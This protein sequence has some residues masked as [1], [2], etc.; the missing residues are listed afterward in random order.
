MIMWVSGF[1]RV[2]R[3][4]SSKYSIILIT[5]VWTPAIT[6][7]ND[8]SAS[9]MMNPPS[10]CSAGFQFL[11]AGPLLTQSIVLLCTFEHYFISSVGI[12]CSPR[13]DIV[14]RSEQIQQFDCRRP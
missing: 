3:I 13:P 14:G 4:G 5:Q 7:L 9:H 10:M 6:S 11:Y 12:A 8:D 2:L 1:E